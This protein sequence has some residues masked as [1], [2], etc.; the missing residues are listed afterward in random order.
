[1]KFGPAPRSFTFKRAQVLKKIDCM[2][3]G[4]NPEFNG[5]IG[6][7]YSLLCAKDCSRGD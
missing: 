2:K 6:T 7:K 1:M 3:T 5:D 4:N